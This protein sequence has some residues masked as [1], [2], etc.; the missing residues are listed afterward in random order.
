[1]RYRNTKRVTQPCRIVV[2][3]SG[4][5]SFYAPYNETFLAEFKNVF[6]KHDRH[7]N[8]DR[9][10]WQIKQEGIAALVEVLQKY[11]NKIEGLDS[12]IESPYD[13]LRVTPE[14]SRKLVRMSAKVLRTEYHPDHITTVEKGMELFPEAG[15]L[16][17]AK[18]MATNFLQ[19]IGEAEKL[20]LEIM[21]SEEGE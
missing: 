9:K 18:E 17:K 3:S 15:S 16:D 2:G 20:I 21:D 7:W 10:I 14:A 8:P 11:Y 5:V 6:N 19:E 4:V 1:M 12:L 13:V